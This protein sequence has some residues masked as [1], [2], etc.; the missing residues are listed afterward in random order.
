MTQGANGR[1]NGPHGGVG[2]R[3]RSLYSGAA[4]TLA[5]GAAKR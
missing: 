4:L 5:M 2:I 3:L 1:A